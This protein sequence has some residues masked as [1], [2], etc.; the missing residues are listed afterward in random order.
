MSMRLILGPQKMLLRVRRPRWGLGQNAQKLAAPGAPGSNNTE[1]WPA[2]IPEKMWEY[3]VKNST[4][5]F[6]I[7]MKSSLH[8]ILCNSLETTKTYHEHAPAVCF[9]VKITMEKS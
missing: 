4:S 6:S 5:K 7:V 2:I 8:S 3:W 1:P 9:V